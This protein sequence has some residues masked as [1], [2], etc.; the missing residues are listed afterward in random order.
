MHATVPTHPWSA[1]G[2]NVVTCRQLPLFCNRFSRGIQRLKHYYANENRRCY[3]PIILVL[4]GS[5]IDELQWTS[6]I[7]KLTSVGSRYFYCL[8]IQQK[9][10]IQLALTWLLFIST[11]TL[12]RISYSTQRFFLEQN[13]TPNSILIQSF[14]AT[15]TKQQVFYAFAAVNCSFG[16]RTVSPRAFD[17]C[18]RSKCFCPGVWH[19]PTFFFTDILGFQVW[20]LVVFIGPR[21]CETGKTNKNKTLFHTYW[22]Q[23]IELQRSLSTFFF[24]SNKEFYNYADDLECRYTFEF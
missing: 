12:I 17:Y 15:T 13:Y 20:V 4:Y 21:T 9:S 1:Y 10:K 8:F 3:L 6:T 2:I 23:F 22:K 16:S 7:V 11:A 24:Y 5:I 18:L 19:E 14:A